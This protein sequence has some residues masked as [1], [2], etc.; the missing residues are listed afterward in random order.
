MKVRNMV[1]EKGNKV[2]NQFVIIN[3]TDTSFQ[4]YDTVICSIHCG[5]AFISLSDYWDYS[6]TTSKYF[7]KFLEENLTNYKPCKKDVMRWLELGFIPA[8]ENYLRTDVNIHHL[9]VL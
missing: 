3:G 5:S 7:Y 6:I 8:N 9:I 4:S 1:S 2:V